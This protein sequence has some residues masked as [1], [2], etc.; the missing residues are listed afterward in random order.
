MGQVGIVDQIHNSY[1]MDHWL[2]NFK[3]WHSILWWVFQVLLTNSYIVYKKVLGQAGES[4]RSHYDYQKL[5]AVSW[6][7]MQNFSGK[8]CSK[9]ESVCLSISTATCDDVSSSGRKQKTNYLNNNALDPQK[10][11]MRYRLNLHLG[12]WLHP[13]VKYK[14]MNKAHYQLCFQVTEREIQNTK[15]TSHYNECVMILCLGKCYKTF[16]T[17]WDLATE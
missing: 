6:I 17:K 10:D 3:W 7:D 12:L 15:N 4:P 8:G 1:K 5:D 13:S 14:S 16:H 9:A 11:W 2:R